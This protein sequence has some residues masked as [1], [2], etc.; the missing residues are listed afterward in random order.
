[1]GFRRGGLK[2][3]KPRKPKLRR[4]KAADIKTAKNKKRSLKFL[5]K[6][7]LCG[8]QKKR[9]GSIEGKLFKIRNFVRRAGCVAVSE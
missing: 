4:F 1:M 3:A 9:A 6:T 8:R 7:E 2:K 5:R